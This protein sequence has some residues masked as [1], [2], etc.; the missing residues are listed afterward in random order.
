MP[1]VRDRALDALLRPV[2]ARALQ[3]FVKPAMHPIVPVALQRTL[4]TTA[5]RSTARKPRGTTVRGVRLGSVVGERVDGLR[6]RA[7]YALLYFHGGGFC[8]GSPL[9]HRSIAAH[10]ARHSGMSVFVP[11]YRLAPEHPYPAALDDALAAYRAL[12]AG[13]YAPERIALVGDSA[14][15]GLALALLVALRDAGTSP[16]ASAVL[17]SPWVDLSLSGASIGFNAADDPVVSPAWL[18]ACA[19]AYAGSLAPNDARLSP[20]FADVHGL[21]PLGIYVGT[22]E[23]LLDDSARLAV[24]AREAGVR[25]ELRC[26]DGLWHNWQFQAGVL[27]SVAPTFADAADFIESSNGADPTA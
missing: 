22:R 23:I 26:Y 18:A 13:G 14:G 16:P 6:V 8:I 10:F 17:L 27:P 5:A 12:L 7:G 25:V 1:S 9:M 19:R 11:A 24:R 21:P 4:V 20:L 15:G 3:T 2:L